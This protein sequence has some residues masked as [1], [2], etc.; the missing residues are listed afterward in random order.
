MRH[1]L[2][3][4]VPMPVHQVV[5]RDGIRLV[6]VIIKVRRFFECALDSADIHNFGLVRRQ[7]ELAYSCRDVRNL[8]LFAE[9]VRSFAPLQLCCPYLPALYEGDAFPVC[10]PAC[11]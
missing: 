5:G 7:C 10:A 3:P 8:Y 6:Q 4:V 9:T 2:D 1:F 11:V